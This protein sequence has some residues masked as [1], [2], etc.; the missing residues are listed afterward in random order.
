MML[1]MRSVAGVGID[2]RTA[3]ARIRDA[4]ITR[5]AADGVAATSVRAIAADADVSPGLVIHHFGSKD[6]LRHECDEYVA[7][8]IRQQKHDVLVSGASFDPVAALRA[9]QSHVPLTRYLARTVIDSSPHVAELI[10]ELVDDA[11]SY[12]ADGVASGMLR[13]TEYPYARAAI[14][15]L[16]SLGM[17]VLHEHVDR[18]LGVDL[19]RD[20][21]RVDDAAEAAAYIG[22]MLELFSNGLISEE[23]AA[24]MRTVFVDGD[25]PALDQE[26]EPAS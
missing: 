1:I 21:S 6:A 9:A 2:D 12:M 18:L 8:V 11:A 26:E 25:A 10:D 23:V 17:L 20:M 14:V 3:R 24:A 19:T 7:A 13:P 16:M 22:P 5:F 4:A 15:T